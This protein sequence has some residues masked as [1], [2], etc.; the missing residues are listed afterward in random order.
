MAQHQRLQLLAHL[1]QLLLHLLQTRLRR[2]VLLVLHRRLLNLQL[3][4]LPLQTVDLLRL[5]VQLHA[6]ARARLVHQVDRLVRQEPV[7]N[8]PVRQ[9]RRQHQRRVVDPHA[10]VT[11]VTV[12]QPAQNAHRVLHARLAHVHLLE[13]T[14]KRRVLLH[15][16][17]VLLQSRRADHAQLTTRQHRLQQVR[18]VHRAVRLARAQQQ[19]HLVDEQNDLALALLHLV[20]HRLQTLL[21]LAA[22]LR[23]SNQRAQVQ[24]HQTH[25]QRLR[26]VALHDTVR[27]TLHNGRLTHTWLAD[28]HWV[29]LRT[30]TQNTNHT[31]DLLVT[32]NHRI[33]LA[34]LRLLHQVH[35]V[36]VQRVIRAFRSIRVCRGVATL[37]LDRRLQLLHRQ[38]HTLEQGAQH[39]VVEQRQHQVVLRH[40]R[41]LVR[42]SI[43]LSDLQHLAQAR[44]NIQLVRNWILL[45]QLL[46]L[47]V[48]LLPQQ[49]HIDSSLLADQ[50][51]EVLRLPQHRYCQMNRGDLRICILLSELLCMHKVVVNVVCKFTLIKRHNKDLMSFQLIPDEERSRLF[52]KEGGVLLDSEGVY[53][54]DAVW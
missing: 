4:L 34:F 50:I 23:A 39:R 29:V 31:T 16:L 26:N 27:Q 20:H 12:L 24:R 49:L 37:L 19:V 10:V 36:L 30:T 35:T 6:D 51:G 1:R 42:H 11:L 5:A 32:T 25:T 41:V 21:E 8:V 43:V 7:L 17:L 22:V 46:Q 3:Q 38:T 18:R 53:R 40:T 33:D 13:T 15:V 52:E 54:F 44:A 45:G 9:L 2:I 28:Q 48:Q 14:L 47:L